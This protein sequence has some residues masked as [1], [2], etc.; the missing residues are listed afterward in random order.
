MTTE[1]IVGRDTVP[2]ASDHADVRGLRSAGV[3]LFV[4]TA[5]FLL[6]TMLA[7]SIAPAYDFHGAAISDLGVIGETALLFNGLLVA[8]GIL[9]IVGGFLLYRWHGRAWLL[10]LYVL[11][12]GGAVGAGVFPLSTGGPHSVFALIAFLCFNLEGLGTA[13]LTAGPLRSIG[14]L[15][16]A[17]G[18]VYAV[19]MVIGDAGNPAVFGPIGHGGSERMIAYPVMLWLLAYSGYLMGRAGHEEGAASP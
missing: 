18:L 11:A 5:T 8:I 3:L 9:N 15:A 6:G 4:L 12:G 17:V 7:A 14:L 10:A 16:G 1:T 2:H 19:L 13:A